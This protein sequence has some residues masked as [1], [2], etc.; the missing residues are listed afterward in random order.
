MTNVWPESGHTGFI[1]MLISCMAQRHYY[2]AGWPSDDYPPRYSPL[3]IVAGLL[4]AFLAGV[5]VSFIELPCTGGVYL[6]ILAMLSGLGVWAAAALLALYNSMF[7]LPL[8]AIIIAA[9]AGFPPEQLTVIRLEYRQ[10]LRRAGGCV[11]ILL[12]APVLL[13]F[14]V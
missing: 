2:G 7:V 1:V 8:I 10:H 11:L 13:W 6:A 3:F 9:V 14:S 12:G 4:S 5:V